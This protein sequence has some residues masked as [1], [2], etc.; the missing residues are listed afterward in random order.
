M[1][2]PPSWGVYNGNAEGT[3][4]SGTF[5]MALLRRSFVGDS[6]VVYAEFHATVPGE[7]GEFPYRGGAGAITLSRSD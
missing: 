2:P 7:G 6:L 4:G 1:P 5:R 3:L